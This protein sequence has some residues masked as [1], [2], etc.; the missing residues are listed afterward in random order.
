M[1]ISVFEINVHELKYGMFVSS[2]DRPWLETPFPIQGFT[3]KSDLD[4]EHVSK[5]CEYVYIDVQ[6]SNIKSIPKH[7]IDLYNN[8]HATKD[9]AQIYKLTH[10]DRILYPKISSRDDELEYAKDNFRIIEGTYKS[11]LD[12][13]NSDRQLDIPAVKKAI[14]PMVRSIVRNPDAYIW[15]TYL[16]SINSYTYHHAISCSVWAVAFGR[17]LGLPSHMLNSL[18]TGCFLF[19]IGKGKLPKSLLN[20]DKELSQEEFKTIQ[21]HVSY[22]LE[23]AKKQKGVDKDIL[24]MIR[25]HHERHNGSGYPMQIKKNSIP[26]FG[27]IAGLVDVYDAITSPRPFCKPVPTFEAIAS[28]YEWRDVEFQT[29]LI[30]QFIQVVGIYPVG[31]LVEL[32]DKTV[33]VVIAQSEYSRLRPQIMILLDKDKKLLKEFY[34]VDLKNESDEEDTGEDET[35][36]LKIAKG[37][38]PGAYDLDH[39]KFYF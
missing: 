20:S 39:T 4:K 13:V 37:L 23:I 30:E 35:D 16:K 18:A 12:D 32:S 21:K 9:S 6:K 2:L 15:L 11:L 36:N 10:L 25:T 5:Y 33:G 28:L 24:D 17:H 34:I 14:I 8:P 7:I 3:V 38:P 29:E 1:P 19:D 31:S 27:R 26:L 22:G